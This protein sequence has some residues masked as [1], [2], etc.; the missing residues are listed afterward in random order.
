MRA[1][2]CNHRGPYMRET[3]DSLS[4]AVT[5]VSRLERWSRSEGGSQ[6]LECGVTTSERD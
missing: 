5:T 3:G 6:H 2:E 1:P 4:E